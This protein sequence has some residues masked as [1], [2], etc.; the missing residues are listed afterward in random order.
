MMNRAQVSAPLLEQLRRPQPRR[1]PRVLG[2]GPYPPR[3]PLMVSPPRPRAAC[4]PA[5]PASIASSTCS[6]GRSSAT[7]ATRTAWPET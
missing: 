7:P 3:R 1:A 6:S 4:W 5:Q 2:E